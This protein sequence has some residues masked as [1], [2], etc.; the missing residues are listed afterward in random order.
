[1]IYNLIIILLQAEKRFKSLVIIF[2]NYP[3]YPQVTVQSG[4][5][6][7]APYSRIALICSF[8][9]QS[10]ITI[11]LLTIPLNDCARKTLVSKKTCL[12]G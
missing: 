6:S 9:S 10:A 8:K 11:L 4:T 2:F 12:T 1:M 5:V 7:D 3:L